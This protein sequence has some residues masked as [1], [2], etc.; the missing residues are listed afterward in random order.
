MRQHGLADSPCALGATGHACWGY[1]D[2][3]ADFRDAAV[4]F[5]TEGL[6]L[7]QRLMFVGGPQTEAAVR[8]VEPLR[9]LVEDGSLQVAPFDAVYPGGR[10]L[11]NAE[12]WALYAAATDRALAEGHAGLRVLAEVTSL[13]SQPDAWADHAVWESYADRLMV[14]HPLSALCCFDRT[15]LDDRA[16]SA[17]A[18]A[19]PVVDRRLEGLVP[20][21]LFG[22]HEPDGGATVVRVAGEVDAFSAE[23]FE[24]LLDADAD[25]APAEV[26]LDLGRL[27]FIDHH[28]VLCIARYA[29][30]VRARGGNVVIVHAPVVY[31]RLSGLLGAGA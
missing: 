23:D 30:Q 22:D 14:D 25:R 8:D 12:Q 29:E 5:L 3:G 16:L 7:G 9:S 1:G 4:A 18:S 28:G 24:R 15:V 17:I 2:A 27:D 26:L 13:A 20:F 10:R 6:A 11:D 31:D 21:R 19:H